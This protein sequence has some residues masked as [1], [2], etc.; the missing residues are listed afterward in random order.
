[1]LIF[2]DLDGPLLD[3]SKK[4]YEVYK[5]LVNEFQGQSLTSEEYWTNK[6]NI[7]PETENLKRSN[8][9]TDCFQN[10]FDK[11]KK[12]IE[13]QKYWSLDTV[14]TELRS[15]LSNS[16]LC[17]KLILVTLRHDK[18]QLEEQ[19]KF[20]NVRCWFDSILSNDGDNHKENRHEAKVNLIKTNFPCAEG[21]FIGDTETDIRCGKALG[22]KTVG[23][24]FG[25]RAHDLISKENPDIIVNSP[26]ELVNWVRTT[27]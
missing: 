6:R 24:T 2:F 18:E 25:I 12:L 20:L 9:S 10:Y 5:D 26:A 22:I 4:Y 1:M 7:I 8:I 3:V 21:W 19:L 13:C 17:G 15:F 11:R 27:E 23:V 16:S 14:W